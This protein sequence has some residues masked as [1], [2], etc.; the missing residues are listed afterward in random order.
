M[1]VLFSLHMLTIGLLL[2]YVL[3][4]PHPGRVWEILLGVAIGLFVSL[5]VNAFLRD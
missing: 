3:A 1:I 2:R 5:G 4:T